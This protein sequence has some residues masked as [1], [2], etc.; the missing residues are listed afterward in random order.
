MR[1]G[2]EDGTHGRQEAEKKDNM[3]ICPPT[4]EKRGVN[5]MMVVP[6][7]LRR[8]RIIYDLSTGGGEGGDLSREGKI[9]LQ[10]GDS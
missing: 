5:C 3:T 8:G 10:L 4:S 9:R 1:Q 7:H 6:S 2:I